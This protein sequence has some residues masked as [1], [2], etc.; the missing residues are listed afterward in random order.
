MGKRRAKGTGTIK[1]NPKT[2]RYTLRKT[3]GRKNNGQRKVFTVTADTQNMCNRLMREKETKWEHDKDNPNAEL[4]VYMLCMCHLQ[5]QV[6]Q[7]ELK[8]KS[9]DRR[10][11]TLNV[12]KG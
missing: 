7:K 2:K 11:D 3:V 12:I 1:Y 10:V 9:I 8:P 5:H 4:D 6:E